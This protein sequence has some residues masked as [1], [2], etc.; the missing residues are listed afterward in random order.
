MCCQFS[1]LDTVSVTCW[2]RFSKQGSQFKCPGPYLG[3]E[4]L[5]FLKCQVSLVRYLKCTLLWK[6]Q[7]LNEMSL[8]V[9]LV[10]VQLASC[11]C[12]FWFVCIFQKESHEVCS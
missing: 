1:F 8:S 10:C 2:P 4:W 9:L 7:L 5:D 6:M 12:V 11:F 3:I